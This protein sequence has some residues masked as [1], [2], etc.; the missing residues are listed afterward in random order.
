M[1]DV[2]LPGRV[3]PATTHVGNNLLDATDRGMYARFVAAGVQVS[4]CWP[5][6]DELSLP[7]SSAKRLSLARVRREENQQRIAQLD[8]KARATMVT[9]GAATMGLRGQSTIPVL[10]PHGPKGRPAAGPLYSV[11]TLALGASPMRCKHDFRNSTQST[12]NWRSTH[13]REGM[14]SVKWAPNKPPVPEEPTRPALRRPNSAFPSRSLVRHPRPR[15]ATGM[16]PPSAILAPPTAHQPRTDRLSEALAQTVP[17]PA[18]VAAAATARSEYFNSGVP[19]VGSYGNAV[20]GSGSYGQVA[21][22]RNTRPL[23]PT[24]APSSPMR[25][26][27]AVMERAEIAAAGGD[28]L[29]VAFLRER[30]AYAAEELAKAAEAA[31]GTAEA[32]KD[33]LG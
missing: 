14:S 3:L 7:E 22:V 25:L 20:F 5:Q 23:P 28:E 12:V 4:F 6:D 30:K 10:E 17:N 19:A 8:V 21:P 26:P 18:A 11:Q 29:F 15:T 9:D 13:Q 32:P 2:R 31:R 24:P 16:R 27:S 1:E 33:W